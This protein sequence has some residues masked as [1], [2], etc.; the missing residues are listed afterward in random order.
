M[1]RSKLSETEQEDI[2]RLFRESPKTIAELS[3]QYGVSSSTIRRMVKR[4]LSDEDYDRLV[5]AKQTV[6]RKSSAAASEALKGSPSLELGSPRYAVSPLTSPAD[7]PQEDAIA[8]DEGSSPRRRKRRR[9]SALSQ[10]AGSEPVLLSEPGGPES[11]MT[12][13]NRESSD[14]ES[15]DTLPQ[16]TPPA[17]LAQLIEE[18]EHDL[19]DDAPSPIDDV[20]ADEEVD[21]EDPAE[22]NDDALEG[23]D[24]EAVI[25]EVLHLEAEAAVEVLP[26]GKAAL[27]KPCYLVV[28]RSGELVTR[29]LATFADLGQIPEDEGQSQTLPVFE[30]HRMA[31]RFSQRSQRILK[32]PSGNLITKASTHLHAKGITRLLMNGQVYGL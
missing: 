2:I 26:L 14:I 18:I 5:A 10:P 19:E 17:E 3:R 7:T 4:H 1:T 13:L 16:T 30:N 29:P 21:L 31:R 32:L 6:A 15:S 22:D 20:D 9:S 12:A 8:S 25:A 11:E 24:S 27:S 23:L 28:D